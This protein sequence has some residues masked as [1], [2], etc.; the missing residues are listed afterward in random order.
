MAQDAAVRIQFN[1]D[2]TQFK[3][4]L[5][6]IEDDLSNFRTQ[7]KTATGD[8]IT[9]ITFKIKGL[10]EEKRALQTFG[11]FAENTLGR[12]QQELRD[13]QQQRLEVDISQI[14]IIDAKIEQL[15]D[16][17]AQAN[18]QFDNI[19]GA[20]KKARTALTSLNLIVQDLPFGFIAIQNNLPA[21]AQTFTGLTATSAGLSGALKALGAALIGPAGLFLAFT[22][23]TTA[24]TFAIQKYGSFGAAI[25]S[26]FGKTN[27]F[28]ESL[29]KATKSFKE[30]NESALSVNEIRNKSIA[31]VQDEIIKVQALAEVVKSSTSTDKQKQGALIELKNTSDQYFGTLN[32]NKIDINAL[33]EAVLKYGES[34]IAIATAQGLAN[35][36]AAAFGEFLKTNQIAVNV[37]T[38]I[39]KL[40]S[41]FPDLN[42]QLANYKEQLK[43]AASAEETL[44]IKSAI[45]PELQQYLLLNEQLDE[46]NARLKLQSTNYANLKTATDTAFKSASQF[47]T[48]KKDEESIVEKLKLNTSD[49]EGYYALENILKRVVEAGNIVINN[50][51]SLKERQNAIKALISEDANYFKSIELGKTP[52]KDITLIIE[53]YIAKLKIAILEQKGAANA[54]KLQAQAD[55]NAAQAKEERAKAEKEFQDVFFKGA[56]KQMTQDAQKF[57]QTAIGP[58]NEITSELDKLQKSFIATKDILT[59]L[60]FQPLQDLFTNFL[61]TG[62]F[63]FSEFVKE[64]IKNIK[65]LI[66]QFLATQIIQQL[67]QLLNPM[68]ALASTGILTNPSGIFKRND[69][70]L[71]ESFR[72]I[73]LGRSM[74]PN[75]GGVT[76]Q[77]QVPGQVN[78]MIRGSDLVGTLNRTNQEI[79]RIG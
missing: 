8:D 32:Q 59:N 53:D 71:Q 7:L 41:E 48:A 21:L 45:R 12:L 52:I 18:S 44:A 24:I 9:N 67:T 16:R 3:R 23:I 57:L 11:Y 58:V 33:N 56:D 55:K 54:A 43:S 1:G 74:N 39:N 49:I 6:Q 79:S 27:Q 66:A 70:V 25:D 13:L 14:P 5:Q 17:I 61:E 73:F 28:T 30:Y 72:K 78:F 42:K 76:S 2:A 47:F 69:R 50:T 20:S 46:V 75:L 62:K 37:A 34:L 22:T 65:K 68:G 36:A 26:I 40:K 35:E 64:V 4:T 29:N 38:S 31:S 10:E 63:T 60:F 15:T 19:G 51:N 77:L